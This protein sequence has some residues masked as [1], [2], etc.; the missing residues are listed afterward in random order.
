MS[1]LTEKIQRVLLS[2]RVFEAPIE[3]TGKY[4][5]TTDLLLEEDMQEI[6]EAFK[7]Q[8][9]YRLQ[10]QLTNAEI[11]RATYVERK[12]HM[13]VHSALTKKHKEACKKCN[14]IKE[15]IAKLEEVE[16]HV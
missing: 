2:G 10:K 8:E 11:K 15:N 6:L 12:R 3:K 9:L 16:N 13:W 4:T 7:Y 1:K 5:Y 14:S